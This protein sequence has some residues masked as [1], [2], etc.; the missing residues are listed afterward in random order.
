MYMIAGITAVIGGVLCIPGIYA[1]INPNISFIHIIIVYIQGISG[2]F[3]CLW[4][5]FIVSNTVFFCFEWLYEGWIL[6]WL[7]YFFAGVCNIYIGC[8]LGFGM[9]QRITI[10]K[11]PGESVAKAEEYHRTLITVQIV[12]GCIGSAAGTWAIIFST[13]AIRI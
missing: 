12:S 11:I 9:I 5:F 10:R 2:I 6:Y 8:L 3:I 4:G 13:L 1:R 7:T